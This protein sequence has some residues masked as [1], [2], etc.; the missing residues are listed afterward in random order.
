MRNTILISILL[1]LLTAC[2]K[3]L[4]VEHI[5]DSKYIKTND[6]QVINQDELVL[7]GEA[8]SGNVTEYG[9]V[10]DG[11]GRSPFI[12]TGGSNKISVNM[13]YAPNYFHGTFPG[14]FDA[15]Y[16]DATYAIRAYGIIDGQA[17]YGKTVKHTSG[18]RGSWKRLNN[19]PG[20]LRTFPVSFAVNGKGYVGCGAGAGGNLNDMWEYDPAT[21]TWTQITSYPGAPMNSGFS[22]VIGNKA[23]VGGGAIAGGP[24]YNNYLASSSFY[25][26]D[27][28][29]RNWTRKA[30][31]PYAFPYDDPGI[32][33]SFAFS[34]GGFGF[35]GGGASDLQQKNGAIFKYDP[36]ANYWEEYSLLPKNYRNEII[37]FHY[38]AAFVLDNLAYVGTGFSEFSST[39]K[40]NTFYSWDYQTKEWKYIIEM[41]GPKIAFGI[42][43]ANSG[44]GYMGSGDPSN[45][46]YQFK[47]LS[48]GSVWK[49]V[50]HN[51]DH[52]GTK[53]GVCF[54][55]GNKT[56]M[57]LGDPVLPTLH[58]P[59]RLYEFTHTR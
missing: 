9:F 2:K 28:V 5:T 22:F 16:P 7:S 59:N 33:G 52:Y 24:P 31:I 53:G 12:S 35:A 40:N 17:Y 26:F 27:P 55:I 44:A 3:E 45:D 10:V 41:P 6:L 25:E 36:G 13:A 57:G 37:Y 30:D 20:P 54:T 32:Y 46:L 1:L 4:T 18:P 39:T 50:S 34:V 58:E 19:F 43:T 49:Q 15:I 56:Y 48:S 47:P 51:A 21:D 23:Y 14:H 38:G 8:V 42:G 11:T 29:T